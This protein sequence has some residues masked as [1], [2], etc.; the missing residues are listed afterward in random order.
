MYSHTQFYCFFHSCKLDGLIKVTTSCAVLVENYLGSCVGG[1]LVVAL[2]HNTNGIRISKTRQEIISLFNCTL[3]LQDHVL[4]AH[5]ITCLSFS[6]RQWHNLN[7]L[8][9]ASKLCPCTLLSI[10]VIL[11]SLPQHQL[12]E[13]QACSLYHRIPQYLDITD[14]YQWFI[15]F[16]T[17][18]IFVVSSIASKCT[19]DTI[20]C[21]ICLN[22]FVSYLILLTF[23]TLRISFKITLTIS[24]NIFNILW[25]KSILF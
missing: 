19:F 23:C 22:I 21:N 11:N 16:L 7:L 20:S 24:T 25:Y 10:H 9:N 5:C 1:S 6:L 15:S 13:W 14:K 8:F 4:Y 12:F 17:A 3:F 2:S 18:S